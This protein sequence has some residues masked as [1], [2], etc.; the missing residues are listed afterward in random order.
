MFDFIDNQI[1]RI[2]LEIAMALVSG[3]LGFLGGMKYTSKKNKIGNI[4]NSN[5]RE[6][7]QEIK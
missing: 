3:I 5:V 4:T 6:I 1:L 2:I 7:K